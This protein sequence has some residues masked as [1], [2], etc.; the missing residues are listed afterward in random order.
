MLGD[1]ETGA[2]RPGFGGGDF[3]SGDG[4]T[5]T[6]VVVAV[7]GGFET[8]GV[9]VGGDD[10]CCG[11]SDLFF[12][13]FLL[14]FFLSSFLPSFSPSFLYTFYFLLRDPKHEYG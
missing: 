10:G 14:S 11:V 2:L 6:V 12:L 13:S 1:P 7:S 4:G 5:V 9:A 8:A 3:G